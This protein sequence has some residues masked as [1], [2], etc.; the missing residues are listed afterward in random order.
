MEDFIVKRSKESSKMKAVEKHLKKD[1]REDK[2][3]MHKLECKEC[4]KHHKMHHMKHDKHH[5]DGKFEKVMHE[6]KEHKLHAGS[7]KGPMVKNPK[8]A[9]AIAYSEAKRAKKKK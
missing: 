8:Q 9:I 3:L 7:K 5:K 1:M 4:H 2:A 6:F